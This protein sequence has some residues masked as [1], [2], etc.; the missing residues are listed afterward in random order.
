MIKALLF[1]L[2]GTLIHNSMETLLPP[3]F[4]AITNKV[5]GLIA[6]DKFITQLRS[7]R[8]NLLSRLPIIFFMV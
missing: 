6:P 5:A 4:S 2:E 7:L 3:Y 8:L 1:D